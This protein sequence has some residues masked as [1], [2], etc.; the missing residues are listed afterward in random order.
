M[1][2]PDP[3]AVGKVLSVSL[4]DFAW[5]GIGSYETVGCGRGRGVRPFDLPDDHVMPWPSDLV[6]RALAWARQGED[7]PSERRQFYSTEDVPETPMAPSAKRAAR[8]RAPGVGTGDAAKALPKRRPSVAQLAESLEAITATLPLITD[9]LADL[10]ERTKAM[11]AERDPL[12]A[13]RPSA[14]RRPLG[15]STMIGCVPTSNPA[16]LVQQMPPPKKYQRLAQ[17][18]VEGAFFRAPT[19]F[20][21]FGPDDAGAEQ[22]PQCTGG[23]TCS[24]Q[25][26]STAGLGQLYQWCIEQGGF[27]TRKA[28][29]RLG[30]PSWNVLHE[31]PASDG[32]AD[33]TFSK[34]RGGDDHPEGQRRDCRTVLGTFWGLWQDPRS[35]FHHLG[36]GFDP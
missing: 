12:V 8:K 25:E 10:S 33:A 22:S 16:K 11:E 4:V 21:P 32:Q 36:G 2:L 34:P 35:G 5:G 31:C 14:L 17:E 26:R 6:D 30:C 3:P 28:S 15:S 23:T 20:R 18:E 24:E 19:G 9:Q 1:Q 27:G 29:V 7:D 13:G